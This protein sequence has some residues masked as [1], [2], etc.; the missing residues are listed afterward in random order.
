M[1]KA[2]DKD[3]LGDL[4]GL[5]FLLDQQ[6]DVLQLKYLLFVL[7]DLLHELD[8]DTGPYPLNSSLVVGIV[9]G[10][11]FNLSLSTLTEDDTMSEDDSIWTHPD[12]KYDMELYYYMDQIVQGTRRLQTTL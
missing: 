12:I 8:D 2:K 3:V 7:W 9:P 10:Y 4:Y 6:L 5:S 11:P 1:A